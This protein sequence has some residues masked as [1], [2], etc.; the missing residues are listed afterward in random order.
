MKRRSFP[1]VALIAC[2]AITCSISTGAP[3]ALSITQGTSLSWSTVIGNT[4]QA[5]M[6]PDGGLWVDFGSVVP[7]DGLNYSI[8]REG[9]SKSTAYQVLEIIPGVSGGAVST[10]SVV[11]G[12]FESG[13]GTTANNWTTS[14][15][16]TPTRIGSDAHLGSFSMRGLVLGSAKQGLFSQQLVPQGGSVTAGKTYGFSF[17]AKQVSSGPSFVR[18]YEMQWLNSGGGVVGGTGSQ[19]F[20]ATTGQW[21]KISVPGLVA[22]AGAADAKVSFRFVT[23]AVANAGGEVLIDDVALESISNSG[24][25]GPPEIRNHPFTKQ[26]VANL[27]WPTVAGMEYQPRTASDLNPANW[28]NLAAKL[29]GDGNP[30]SILVPMTLDRQFFRV[31]YAILPLASPTHLQ[32]VYTGSPNSIGL[33]WTASSSPGVTGYRILFGTSINDL[34]G[35]IDVG[36]AVT[37]IVPGLTPGQTYF[38]AVIS[39]TADGQSPVGAVTLSAQPETDAAIVALYNSSTPLEAPTT[40][41]TAAALITRIADRARDRHA[42]EDGFNSYDHYLNWYWEQRVANM[43]IIDRVARNGGTTITFNYTTQAALSTTDFRTFFR[44]INTV[45]EYHSNQ[46]AVLVSTTPSATPGET[47]FNY[48]ATVS[49]NRQFNRPLRLG[50]RIEVEVSQFMASPRNGRK[51][52]YGTTLLYIVGQGIVP[53]AAGKD[54]GFDGGIIGSINQSLDSYPLPVSGWLGGKTTLP[55]QY[56][57]EPEHRFK[58]TAGNISPTN[59]RLFMLG[60]RFHHTDF[61]NG[62]HTEP[63]NPIFTEQIGKLGPKHVSRSCV[64]C[65]DNNGRSLPPLVGAQLLQHGIR[66]GSD[67]TGTPHPILGEQLQPSTVGSAA[68]ASVILAS[69]ITTGGQYNDSTPYSLRK[70]TYA[71]QGVTPSHF[72]VRVAPQL[73]GLGLLEAIAESTILDLADPNDRDGDGISGRIHVIEDPETGEPRLGRFGHKATQ[74]RVDHQIAHALNY[75]MGVTTTVFNI[76]D[77]GTTPS[78]VEINDT[79]LDLMKR[80]VALL[81]VGARRNLSNAQALRGEQLFQ[82]ASCVSCHKPTLTTSPHH[83]MA[84]L[85]NQTIRPYTDMLLHDMGPGLADNMGEKNATG[86]E[87]R[88]PPLWNIGLTAGVSGGEAYLHDGR[89]RTLEEAILWHGGEGEA[90]KQAFLGMS[91]ADRA[92]LVAFLKSL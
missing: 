39:L 29:T 92:A 13:S 56:S 86:S 67:A 26:Q 88:T 64:G 43:E 54:V 50:D 53:W 4:Y 44:G 60:R 25:P 46:G 14:L 71:F 12:G 18:Q 35:S 27:S 49:S 23:G 65:H 31:E 6:A 81:G 20:S 3:P 41:D 52:Y 51:S 38:F 78:P 8:F 17:W 62:V 66:V 75:D 19:N 63:G 36:G 47:D 24:P 69:Y 40:I 79:N 80:Y 74:A 2:A 9:T 85:R 15:N 77:G 73:V 45:A 21:N 84:E 33:A 10:N 91:A 55:Y 89:A 68:E 34:S 32:T 1:R 70:P 37:A 76:P 11:N 7:G 48:T 28:S 57:N 72:S 59:G 83:P 5:R 16:Q 42:R 22:P 82:S 58:Q 87:W 90:S 30:A 61:G